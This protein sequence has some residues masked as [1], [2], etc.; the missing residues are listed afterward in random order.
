[1]NTTLAAL[2]LTIS[3]A[4][5]YAA[6]DAGLL[7]LVNSALKKTE[8]VQAINDRNHL[9]LAR[10]FYLMEHGRAPANDHVLFDEGYLEKPQD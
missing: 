9:K 1:M 5:T 2:A 3:A 8:Q 7:D 4:S 10:Q 6:V